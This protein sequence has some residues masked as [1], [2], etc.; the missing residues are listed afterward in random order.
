MTE[1]RTASFED[2]GK[3]V[4]DP[5][6]LILDVL[7]PEHFTARHLPGALNACVYEVTFLEQ[8]DTLTGGS[9]SVPV[10]VY[11][12]GE[13]S[14][15]SREAAAKL[16]RAGYTDVVV[17]KEGL[18]GWTEKGMSLEGTH[19]MEE[20]P[21]HPVLALEQRQYS[22]IPE[23]SV[24]TWTGRNYNGRHI[25]T[26]AVQSGVLSCEKVGLTGSFA[27]DMTTISN[28]DLAGNELQPVLE[29]HLR[30]DDFFFTSMF[31][32]AGFTITEMTPVD[33]ASATQPNYRVIGTL[34]L[35]GLT[36]EVEFAAN[37]RPLP[38]GR[39]TLMANFDLDRTD[40]G[41]IYGSARF[42][43]HLSYHIV[44]DAISI[45]LRVVLG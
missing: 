44:Y 29:A 42:F 39:I 21:P 36:R 14:L 26:V 3:G 6:V 27:L 7:P 41:V 1:P 4:S 16:E 12:A 33:D 37:L 25:G 30:S 34:N 32:V 11:G 23:E 28:A 43:K 18:S 20:D 5:A 13:G 35:R 8:V 17:F 38:E 22:V 31:P 10:I 45:D 9:R 19:T 40:W 24:V 2:V 15:D